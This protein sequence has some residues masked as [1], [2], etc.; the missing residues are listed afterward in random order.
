[1][2]LGLADDILLAREGGTT[3]QKNSQSCTDSAQTCSCIW[4]LV[5]LACY[6][7]HTVLCFLSLALI[8]AS[9][10]KKSYCPA[11]ASAGSY[12][13]AEPRFHIDSCNM[14]FFSPCFLNVSLFLEQ[15]GGEAR[16]RKARVHKILTATFSKC[17]AE[18]LTHTHMISELV[19]RVFPPIIIFLSQL[20]FLEQVWPYKRKRPCMGDW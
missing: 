18:Q 13:D 5:L 2:V 7:R 14:T 17:G 4:S 8:L 3:H 19:G 11:F 1:M 12:I 20:L 16:E 6:M 9:L 10:F 15:M